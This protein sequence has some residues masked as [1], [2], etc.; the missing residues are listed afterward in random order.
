MGFLI[1][2]YEFWKPCELFCLKPSIFWEI[3]NN[4]K[5]KNKENPATENVTIYVYVP[6]SL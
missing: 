5:E 3:C 6:S 4:K 2:F 1:E